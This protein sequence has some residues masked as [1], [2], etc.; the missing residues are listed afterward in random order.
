MK[1]VIL[2]GGE[3]TRLRPLTCNRPK[4]MIP[5]INKPFLEHVLEYLKKHGIFDVV[6]SMGYKPDVIQE[7]F[8]DGSGFGVNLAYVVE[9]SPLGTAG[10]VKNVE[11]YLDGTCFV[12]NGDIMTDL[13]LGAMLQAHR[14]KGAAVTIA[15]TPVEDPTAYGLVETDRDGRVL[16]FIEK[17][18][19]DRVTTNLINAG[20]YVVEPEV[21]R[22]VPPNDYYMFEHGLFP[23]LVQK[24]EPVFGF[25]SSAYWIDIGTPQKY[26]D[27]HRDLL[28]GKVAKSMP[29]HALQEG[30]WVG[31]GCAIASTARLT[32]PVVLGNR[33]TV[34]QNVVV[35]GP[36]VIGDDCHIGSESV[37]EDV[38][39][40]RGTWIGSRVM[41]KSC[42]VAEKC[43]VQDNAWVTNG[44]IL[45]DSCNIGSGNKL[46]HGIKIWPGKAIEPNAITF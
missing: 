27:V 32:P 20:T 39:M 15:L 10:G 7:Y 44:A 37:I 6:L 4:P 43:V 29:G 14:E 33:V 25:P 8:D 19:W 16:G 35:T 22:Y 3:G 17:P 5:V 36:V 13:D 41:M 28:M 34:E 23:T 40:W 42:V 31:R 2:V 24:G 38:V 1:A 30:V 26:I 18:S 45:A 46:E 12:F 11:R 21:L 9:A